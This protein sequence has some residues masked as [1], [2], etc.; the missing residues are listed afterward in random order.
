MIHTSYNHKTIKQSPVISWQPWGAVV[1]CFALNNF[2]NGRIKKSLSVWTSITSE[3]FE[4]RIDAKELVETMSHRYKKK[5]W[6]NKDYEDLL[7]YSM[8]SK[9]QDFV[10]AANN[11]IEMIS[12]KGRELKYQGISFKIHYVT[13]SKASSH[14]CI[15]VDGG[16][17]G[18]E[19]I[20]FKRWRV[21]HTS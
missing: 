3:G 15:Q 21:P 5:H 7:G 4:M 17:F 9:D 13:N 16:A 1:P 8:K 11:I 6:P 2:T 12:M 19:N 10:E 20:E 18:K 14:A